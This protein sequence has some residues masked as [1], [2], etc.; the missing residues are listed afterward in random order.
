M[1][2]RLPPNIPHV[3]LPLPFLYE[4]TGVETYF[5]DERDPQPRSRRVFTFHRPETLAE[6]LG[7]PDTLR[8]RL[9]EMPVDHPRLQRNCGRRRWKPSPAWRNPSRADK[10]RALIQMA[11]GSGKTYT[12]VSFVYRLIKFA[13]ARRVLFLVDRNNLGR[14]AF[15][16]FDQYRHPGRWAQ[17][18]RAVQRP[19]PAIQHARPGEQGAHHHHPAPVLD[20]LRRGGVR[21]AERGKLAV[22]PGRVAGRPSRRGKC[23]TTR[24]SRSSTYDFI[25][26]DECHRSIYNLWRQ[27]LEY[28]D[29]FLIG[30]TATPSKQTF[31]FFNQNLVMEYSRQRAVADGV[32]VDGQVYRI[33]TQISEAGQHGGERAGG[34]ASATAGRARQRWE[35]LDEDLSYDA[36]GARPGGGGAGPDP[37]HPANL[38]ATGCRW[39]SSPGGR[40]CPRRWCSPRT[41]AT[42]RISCASSARS[43]ARATS[44]ARRSPT[45][46]PEKPEDLISDF[47]NS[48]YPRIAVTVD[49]I[50]TGTDIRPLEILLF[51]RAVR[52]RLLY[53]QM[54]GR[55]TR[56]VSPTDLQK[57]T[58]AGGA[59]GPLRDRGRG[60]ADRA[61][62]DGTADAGAQAL[63]TAEGAAGRQQRWEQWTMTCWARWQGG[64]G[65]WR[66]G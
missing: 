6:W 11:T 42:P 37:H 50:A 61:G 24:R 14:Q 20:A 47:R 66:S 49:M 25:V 64:W 5:R 53:E 27:V 60:R 12:A 26:V 36:G 18:H 10:P 15:K 31:G 34:W 39:T 52:S 30:L 16:E 58:N 41:T 19:A 54:L 51:M 32:N 8:G 9:A 65:C 46:R 22:R 55:G 45:G 44:S 56:V 23:T 29:A 28:F 35:Q 43:S 48:Y 57:V 2:P 1:L 62:V 21:P 13:K 38:S 59:Q 7:Q 40:R 3:T 33:R 63:G 4:S 17:V